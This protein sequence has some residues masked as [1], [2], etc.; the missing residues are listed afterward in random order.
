[1]Y[2]DVTYVHECLVVVLP[3]RALYLPTF[4]HLL[5]VK[6]TASSSHPQPPRLLA[7]P[8]FPEEEAE[9]DG[10][11]AAEGPEVRAARTVGGELGAFNGPLTAMT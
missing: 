6:K 10:W 7:P 8:V 3:D 9:A 2:D 1:M 5:I 4:N 11:G